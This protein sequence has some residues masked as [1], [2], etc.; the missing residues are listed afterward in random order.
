MSNS[1]EIA[2]CLSRI[3]PSAIN[4][5][6]I[7]ANNYGVNVLKTLLKIHSVTTISLPELILPAIFPLSVIVLSDKMY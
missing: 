5:A 3:N 1:S 4:E 7:A 2:I 6:Q